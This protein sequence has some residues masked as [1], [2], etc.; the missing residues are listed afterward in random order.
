MG[1]GGYAAS[2]QSLK[3]A[4]LIAEVPS[5]KVV[6]VEGAYQH[7]LQDAGLADTRATIG[8]TQAA[9]IHIDCDVEEPAKLALDFMTPYMRQGTLLLFDEFDVNR[10]DNAKGERAA[11]RAW[12]KENPGFEI[13]PYRCY[14]VHARSFILHK[15][16]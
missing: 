15:K 6:M 16:S 5:S 12:L 14:H 10:A 8:E 2:I 11:L 13:E 1:D 7:T 3:F 9:V 4:N